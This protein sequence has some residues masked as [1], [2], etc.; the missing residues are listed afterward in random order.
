[1][2][3]ADTGALDE[4]FSLGKTPIRHVRFPRNRGIHP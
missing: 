1:M 4:Y 2:T 3:H